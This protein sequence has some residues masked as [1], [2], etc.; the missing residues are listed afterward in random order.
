MPISPK[1]SNW[2][3]FSIKA[4]GLRSNKKPL[5]L[6]KT[7]MCTF[8]IMHEATSTSYGWE[9]MLGDLGLKVQDMYVRVMIH[10]SLGVGCEVGVVIYI[11]L[12]GKRHSFLRPKV[13]GLSSCDVRLF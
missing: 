12:R 7:C 2:F 5:C 1:G 10:F 3:C 4:L 8:K 13:N 6:L 11:S 9:K